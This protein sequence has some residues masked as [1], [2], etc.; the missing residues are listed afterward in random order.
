MKNN[1]ARLPLI[2]LGASGIK[3]IVTMLLGLLVTPFII[4]RIGDSNFGLYKTI[5]EFFG[6]FSILEFGLYSTLLGL[7]IKENALQS[8]NVASIVKWGVK[9]YQKIVIVSIGVSL[10]FS[11]WF[12]YR[13]SFASGHLDLIVSLI[14]C[15]V[16]FLVLPYLPYKALLESHHK[17]YIVNWLQL[18]NSLLFTIGAVG[19]SYFHPGISSQ[20]LAT[21]I[22]LYF[23]SKLF[24]TFANI[25]LSNSALYDANDTGQKKL[26]LSYFLNELSGRICLMCDNLIIALLLRSCV[27]ISCG[28]F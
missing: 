24:K 25:D 15:Q 28:S 22:A 21:V 20:I 6:H 5:V 2:N 18:L 10:L 9:S 19:I 27:C 16:F 8:N 26:R 4:R 3:N 17:N 7:L 23:S 12:Y 11:V 13:F 1:R 14:L